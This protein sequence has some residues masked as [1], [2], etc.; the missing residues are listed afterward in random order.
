MPFKALKVANCIQVVYVSV[1][2]PLN[3]VGA[4]RFIGLK[5]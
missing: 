4:T 5:I 2:C 1:F 3:L